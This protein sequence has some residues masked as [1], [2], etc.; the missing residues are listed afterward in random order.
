MRRGQTDAERKLWYAVRAGR[1]DGWKFRRQ[2]PI[3]RYIVDFVCPARRLI[4]ELD[5]GQHA[6]QQDYDA[7]RTAFL[8][9]QGYRVMRFQNGEVLRNL[10][11]VTGQIWCTLTGN[12]PL[13]NPSPLEGEGL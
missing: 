2:V 5:G 8:E 6:D 7:A 10:V 11:E 12:L 13:P 1:L 4:V 3:G 9:G